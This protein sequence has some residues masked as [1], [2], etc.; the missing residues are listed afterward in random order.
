MKK[1]MGAKKIEILKELDRLGGRF[2]KPRGGYWAFFCRFGEA[3]A[4]ACYFYRH[5]RELI[6]KNYI[7]ETENELI[8]TQK[9]RELLNSVVKEISNSR[10]ICEVK[11]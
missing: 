11:E 5:L 7:K 2:K 3:N 8:L 1:M 10:V 6:A 4:Y 9:G